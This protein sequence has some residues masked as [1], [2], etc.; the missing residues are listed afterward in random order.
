MFDMDRKGGKME[1]KIT[2]RHLESTPSIEEKIRDKASHLEKYFKG[3][4]EVHWICGVEKDRHTSEVNVH[5]GHHYFNA[6]A[7]DDDL[8]KTMDQALKKIEPQIREKNKQIKDHIH[9]S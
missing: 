6:K 5:A 9:R 7:E 1:L 2:Y 4:M 8:Y 3:N